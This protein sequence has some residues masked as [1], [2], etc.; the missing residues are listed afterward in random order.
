TADLSRPPPI[1]RVHR[2]FIASTADLSRPPPIYRVHR[3]FI[4]STADLSANSGK[5]AASAPETRADKSA[6][7]TINRPLRKYKEP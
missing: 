6:V 2:R 5:F 1:Y 7:G 3:R 4:A